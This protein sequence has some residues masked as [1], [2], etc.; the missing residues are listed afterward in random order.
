MEGEDPST[1]QLR[2]Y[3]GYVSFAMYCISAMLAAGAVLNFAILWLNGS[4]ILAVIGG[5]S[6]FGASGYM[7]H[8]AR[9]LYDE[10]K[11]LS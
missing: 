2:R 6:M 9:H 7:I 5:V 11:K 8:K 10:V 3:S 1:E 4:P